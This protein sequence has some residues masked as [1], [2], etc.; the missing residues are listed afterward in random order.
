MKGIEVKAKDPTIKY[1]LIRKKLFYKVTTSMEKQ[2]DWNSTIRYEFCSISSIF[3]IIN[4]SV[5]NNIK[6][7]VKPDIERKLLLWEKENKNQDT[8]SW[9]YQQT[10]IIPHYNNVEWRSLLKSQLHQKIHLF[11]SLSLNLYL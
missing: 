3:K 7:S 11:R 4:F 1:K 2:S 8:L 5:D 6:I 9:V 10:K